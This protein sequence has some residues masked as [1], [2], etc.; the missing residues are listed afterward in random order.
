MFTGP[1]SDPVTFWQPSFSLPNVIV[2]ASEKSAVAASL[3]SVCPP[4][5]AL[6]VVH[7]L[8]PSDA[9]ALVDRGRISL[10]VFSEPEQ[11]EGWMQVIINGTLRPKT[12]RFLLLSR[13]APVTHSQGWIRLHPVVHD[14]AALRNLIQSCVTEA[15]RPPDKGQITPVDLL[16]GAACLQEAAWVRINNGTA[17]GDVCFNAGSVVYAET[18]RKSGRAAM[19]EILSW[20]ACDFEYREFPAVLPANVSFSLSEVCGARPAAPEPPPAMAAPAA[21]PPTAVD[22]EEPL[23]FPSFEAAEPEPEPLTL[24]AEL[25]I[26]EPEEFPQIESIAAIPDPEASIM[27]DDIIGGLEPEFPDF[28]SA[29]PE[30]PEPNTDFGLCSTIFLSVTVIENGLIDTCV[31][32]SAYGSVDAPAIFHL[33]H[34]MERYSEAQHMGATNSVLLRATQTTLVVARVPKTEKLLAARLSGTKFGAA[35]EMELNRLIEQVL[36]PVFTQ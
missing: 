33:F 6:E 32:A 36:A 35:E 15:Q 22:L 30:E 7:A 13:K 12:P 14:A 20:G 26:E 34:G 16:R 23:D 4:D 10:V 24:A 29:E 11:G 21:P 3:P 31:P 19:D 18:G 25:D 27:A 8:K 2:V 28:D 17:S 5:A 1:Q 9:V